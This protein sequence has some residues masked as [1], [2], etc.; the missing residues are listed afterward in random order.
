ML[1]A[2]GCGAAANAQPTATLDPA[3]SRQDAGGFGISEIV[4]T[5]RKRSERLL[6]VGLSV[7]AASEVQLKQI[8]VN[9]VQGLTRVEPSLQYSASFTGEPVYTIR[10][11]GFF[12]IG[13]AA[14]PAVSLYQDETPYA[15]PVMSSG[16]LFDVQQ[17]EILK[18]PQGILYG[19]NSTGGAINFITNKPTRD[20]RAG[21]YGSLSRFEAAHFEG[22]V[23]GPL[24]DTLG[25]RA[26]LTT[27]QGGAWQQS[28]TRDDKL[29]NKRFWAGRVLA[30]WRPTA[31]LKVNLNL[32]GFRDRS[33]TQ[34][35]QFRGFW[36]LTPFAFT[37]PGGA[38]LTNNVPTPQQIA[39]GTSIFPAGFLP[40]LRNQPAPSNARAADWTAGTHPRK[41]QT[42][43]QASLRLDWSLSPQIDLTSLTSY[44]HFKADDLIDAGGVNVVASNF[45]VGSHIESVVQELR[46]KGRSFED[47]L[48]WMVGANY[49][50]DKSRQVLDATVN[51]SASYLG[52]FFG[53]PPIRT[54]GSTLDPTTE[55]KAAFANGSYAITPELKLNAGVRYTESSLTIDG[56]SYGDLST[57][58]INTGGLI[59]TPGAC[60]TL[61]SNGSRGPVNAR[62]DE[63]NTPWRVGLDW[64]PE[65]NTLL[66]A[67]VS[68]GFKAASAPIGAVTSYKQIVPA[69]QETVT[70]YELGAKSEMI[71]RAL[72]LTG[73][74]FYY[75]YKGKQ[76]IGRIIDP[77][78][79]PL[80]AVVSIPKSRLYGVEF[81]AVWR[82]SGLTA[83][84]K[85]THLNSRV[86]SD[87]NNFN[88][89]GQPVN[90]KGESFPFAP[91]WSLTAGLRYDWS[92]S[93]TLAAYASTR[94]YYQSRT[95]SGFGNAVAV[96]A[97]APSLNNRGY[98]L[99]DLAMGLRPADGRWRAEIWGRNVTNTYYWTAANYGFDET[100]RFAGMPATFGV[101][102]DYAF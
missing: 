42:F 43:G 5:A 7:T 78:F 19:Q 86:T 4:V 48:N 54:L 98:A 14:P 10:G 1:L 44:E 20:T 59:A 28:A 72:T 95:T 34:A 63:H 15:F 17:V 25:L 64:K 67:V 94:A 76:L 96:A 40:V 71:G 70:A 56:C 27:D 38:P 74:A 97:G 101:S 2:L 81:D 23:S 35:A 75:D 90:F 37:G 61:R 93:D 69:Q 16:S 51:M 89:Y 80:Q 11:V 82:Q 8:G 9:S 45:L 102:L 100:T 55:T 3:A 66:Y 46:L 83:D 49:E 92:I 65:P 31:D 6:D 47:R 32:S 79:G 88:S 39:A 87:F 84:L 30:E 73:A 62:L 21:V 50:R 24:S 58:I 91:K 53:L 41:D 68:R 36:L 26:A 22:F 99:L 57:E 12:Q 77:I 85:G 33:D 13:A 18:G 52:A 60:F 29:G